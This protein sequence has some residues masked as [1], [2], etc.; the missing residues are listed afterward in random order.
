MRVVAIICWG[1]FTGMD[2]IIDEG[3][4]HPFRQGTPVAAGYQM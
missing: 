4:R 3:G 1:A 2:R